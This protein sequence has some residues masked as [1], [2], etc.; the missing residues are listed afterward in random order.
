LGQIKKKKLFMFLPFYLTLNTLFLIVFILFHNNKINELENHIS[1]LNVA[2]KSSEEKVG[3]L[4]AQLKIAE[5]NNSSGS[6]DIASNH[7]ISILGASFFIGFLALLY[8]G[9]CNE[10]FIKEI[11]IQNINHQSE[12]ATLIT[13]N[14][15]NSVEHLLN[16]PNSVLLTCFANQKAQNSLSFENL[17]HLVSSSSNEILTKV[18]N[19]INLC[20][21][22]PTL[23][24]LEQFNS[25][26][27][28]VALASV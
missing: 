26:D 6:L 5:L 19:C 18:N 8:F 24:E 25:I 23:S 16:D 1:I 12:S 20:H 15:T 14:I 27:L 17:H 28:A 21:T 2:K 10:C 13:K 4:N 3:M 22:A 9:Y 11:A 7:N